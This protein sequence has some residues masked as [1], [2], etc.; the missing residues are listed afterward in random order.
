MT[1][2]TRIPRGPTS[3][4]A[5]IRAARSRA[6]RRSAEV[7]A[8][9]AAPAPPVHRRPFVALDR[10]HLAV[11]AGARPWCPIAVPRRA[12]TG[13]RVAWAGKRSWLLE[14]LP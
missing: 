9:L 7:R 6:G 5:A 11:A 2:L 14:L 3:R 13:Q 4:E 8:R 1:H 10:A 12:P